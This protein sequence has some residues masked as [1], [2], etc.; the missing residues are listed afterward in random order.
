MPV[1]M[2]QNSKCL[3][4]SQIKLKLKHN[5]KQKLIQKQ[6]SQLIGLFLCK[7]FSLKKAS[8]QQMKSEALTSRSKILIPGKIKFS[9]VSS[10]TGI[11]LT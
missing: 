11:G 10:K 5:L 6:T 1:K 7:I 2:K 3:G 4:E 9:Q 8:K